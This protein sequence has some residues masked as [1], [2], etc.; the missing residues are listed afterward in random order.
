[1]GSIEP[2]TYLQSTLQLASILSSRFAHSES[3]VMSASD[4][5]CEVAEVAKAALF[6]SD[7]FSFITK[8]AVV[9]VV[10]LV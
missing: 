8:N 4:Q 5:G 1:M 10:K 3:I 9:S 7:L 6:L 2:S